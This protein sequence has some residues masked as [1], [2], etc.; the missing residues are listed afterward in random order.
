[1]SSVS[2]IQYFDEIKIYRIDTTDNQLK[3]SKLETSQGLLEI[4]LDDTSNQINLIACASDPTDTQVS[5]IIY[6]NLNLNDID[7]DCLLN[8]NPIEPNRVEVKKNFLN[9][10]CYFNALEFKTQESLNQFRDIIKLLSEAYLCQ[11]QRMDG[12]D[13]LCKLEDT[14]SKKIKLEKNLDNNLDYLC[15]RLSLSIKYGDVESS[16]QVVKELAL[17]SCDLYIRPNKVIDLDRSI[18]IIT[19]TIREKE[20]D[21]LTK[22]LVCIKP[23]VSTERF[24]I[25]LDVSRATVLDLKIEVFF[26]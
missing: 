1:M 13:E 15:E 16:I 4:H 11:E 3:K 26:K 18:E 8:K 12:L 7:L 19:E 14:S 2:I 23:D 5:R 10:N 6:F 25:S 17:L 24:E 9:K 21:N 20:P 22:I